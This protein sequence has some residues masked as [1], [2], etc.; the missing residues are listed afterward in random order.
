MSQQD[1]ST[2]ARSVVR[3]RGPTRRHLGRSRTCPAGHQPT[4]TTPAVVRR[5]GQ[6]LG[7]RWLGPSAGGAT[8]GRTG[9]RTSMALLLLL[10]PSASLQER[11]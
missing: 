7:R 8:L 9:M 6:P 1:D 10:S 2:I 4:S 5:A 11:R 3:C